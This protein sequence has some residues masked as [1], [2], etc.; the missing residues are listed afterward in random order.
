MSSHIEEDELDP[1][2]L[3]ERRQ[4]THRAHRFPGKF[5]PPL[6]AE[7]IQQHPEHEVIG[8]P[9]CGSGTT[10]VESVVAGKNTLCI[11][12]DPLSA[13][14]TRA[15]TKPVDVGAFNEVCDRIIDQVSG[16]PEKGSYSQERA[17]QEVEQNI[18]VGQYAI[19]YNLFHWFDPYV[20]VGYSRLLSESHHVLKH[21]SNEMRD[22]VHTA[23]A[24]MVRQISRADPDPVSGLEVTKIRRQELNDGIT[25]DVSSSFNN[26]SNRLARGY[27]QLNSLDEIGESSVIEGDAKKFSDICSK[28]DEP[29]SMIITSPPYCNAIEYS[30]RHRLEYEWLGLFNNPDVENQRN[31]RIETSRDFFGSTTPKQGT[32]RNLPEVPH[33]DIKRVTGEIEEMGHERKANLLRKYFLDAYDWISEIYK[34]LPSGGLFCMIIGPSTSYG[35]TIDTPNY[36]KEITLKETGFELVEKPRRYK[37]VNNKMQYPTNGETTELECLLKFRAE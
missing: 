12:I 14:M 5:H 23:L 17:R 4:Y 21:E 16:F 32:L 35:K 34:A 24:A 28:V 22:A 36:L 30:R 6:I 27:E 11:D 29:P 26:V 15:K 10:G 33:T 20:A 7:I 18:S 9:M 19:P 8:D 31:Q 1:L 3:S 13:L 2:D 25:F 37:L